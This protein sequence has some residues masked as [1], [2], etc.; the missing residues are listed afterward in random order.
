MNLQLKT[1]SKTI[2]QNVIILFFKWI[3]I[4]KRELLKFL[5]VFVAMGL[6]KRS[7]SLLSIHNGMAKCFPD[8]VLRQYI[9]Q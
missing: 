1:F 6:D 9:I 4:T 5:A 7:I 3:L 2:Q 8:V